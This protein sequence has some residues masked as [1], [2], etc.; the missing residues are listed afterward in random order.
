MKFL[1]RILPMPSMFLFLLLILYFWG[2]FVFFLLDGISTAFDILLT[3]LEYY[4][5][6]QTIQNLHEDGKTWQE[7]LWL[8][9]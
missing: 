2:F 9:V 7:L 3:C 1:V 4:F 8:E 6:P 5:K